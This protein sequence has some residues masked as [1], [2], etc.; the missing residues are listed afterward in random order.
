MILDNGADGY[1]YAVDAVTGDLA[2]ETLI[3]DYRAGAKNSS[4][5][6]SGRSTSSGIA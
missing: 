5:P 2:W 3:L 6:I 1:A 4:G